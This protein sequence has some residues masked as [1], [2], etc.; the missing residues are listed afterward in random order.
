MTIGIALAANFHCTTRDITARLR[1]G[2]G[3]YDP[4]PSGA[5]R[6]PRE[7]CEYEP[8]AFYCRDIVSIKQK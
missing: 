3:R 6:W 2:L 5:F 7:L 4:G 1:S 8:E